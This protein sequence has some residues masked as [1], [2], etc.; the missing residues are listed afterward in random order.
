MRIR[1][2]DVEILLVSAETIPR[3]KVWS[4]QFGGP[5]FP[6]L[7]DHWPQARVGKHRRYSASRSRAS[8]IAWRSV[9]GACAPDTAVR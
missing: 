8:S 6:L 4:G 3:L 9:S 1:D 5:P 2:V 7:S